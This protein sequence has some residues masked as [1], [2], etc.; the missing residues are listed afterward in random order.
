MELNCASDLTPRLKPAR[1]GFLHAHFVFRR[2]CIKCHFEV[3][4]ASKLY[5]VC[6]SNHIQKLFLIQDLFS[7]LHLHLK[8]TKVAHCRIVSNDA[9]FDSGFVLIFA[10]AF[11][12]MIVKDE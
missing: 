4:S 6:T 3:T 10:L 7:Y 5:F 12:F 2:V 9:E 11:S 8:K 1:N